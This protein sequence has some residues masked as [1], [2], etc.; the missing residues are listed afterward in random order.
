MLPWFL[1]FSEFAE[2]NEIYAP[3]RENPIEQSALRTDHLHV[4]L[5]QQLSVVTD[6]VTQP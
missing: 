5:S 4:Q 6:N 2:F 1:R 3:F